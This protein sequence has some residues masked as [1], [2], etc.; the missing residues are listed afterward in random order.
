MGG[1]GV[2][3]NTLLMLL[4]DQGRRWRSTHA[5]TQSSSHEGTRPHLSL[6]TV[7]IKGLAARMG[8]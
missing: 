5:A 7:H 6:T 4:S 1:C 3:L 2:Y 8:R